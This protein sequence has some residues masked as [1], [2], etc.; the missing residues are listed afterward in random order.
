MWREVESGRPIQATNMQPNHALHLTGAAML[1]SRDT[2][3]LRRLRQ[4][5]LVVRPFSREI[6]F[7]SAGV[8]YIGCGD[9]VDIEQPLS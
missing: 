5:S 3:L 1:I 6:L 9:I 2:T 8:C 7:R 4:V